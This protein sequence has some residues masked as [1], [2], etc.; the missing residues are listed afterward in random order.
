MAI[1]LGYNGELADK[2][3]ARIWNELV[4]EGIRGDFAKPTVHARN[5]FHSSILMYDIW[6]VHD[7]IADTYFIGKTLNNTFIEFDGFSPFKSK[8]ESVNEAISYAMYRLITHRYSGTPGFDNL[9][10]RMMI[11]MASI[12]L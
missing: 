11:L 3:I 7:E 4:L 12:K 5:L 8:A 2:S 10:Q 1:T 9:Y 6:A